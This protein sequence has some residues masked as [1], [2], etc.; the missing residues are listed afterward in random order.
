[1]LVL[2]CVAIERGAFVEGLQLG[3]LIHD[4]LKLGLRDTILLHLDVKGQLGHVLVLHLAE[5]QA[6]I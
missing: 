2:L 6:S 1:M 4:A 3:D 5:L